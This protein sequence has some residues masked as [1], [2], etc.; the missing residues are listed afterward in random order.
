MIRPFTLRDLTLV[1]RLA[2]QGISLHAESAL[3]DSVN[4]L[5]GALLGIL[6][7]GN[8]PTFV[9][10]ST[11]SNE[12]GFL[13]LRLEEERHHAHI[14]CISPMLKQADA[15]ADTDADSIVPGI[16]SIVN[17]HIWLSLLDQAV[18]EAGRHG[19]HSLVAEVDETG[20]EL[21][22]L[23]RAG[24]AV[25][26][27]QDIWV[28]EDLPAAPASPVDLALTPRRVV[29][30]WDI[31]LL[32]A[33]TVPRL[34]QLAEPV[35]PLDGDE[36]W[37]LRD[38]DDLAAYVHIHL[39]SVATWLRFFI[40]PNAESDA[41]NIVAAALQVQSS[42]VNLPIFCCVRRYESWLP[43][44]LERNG[45]HIYSS[46]AVMVKHTVHHLKKPMSE[47]TAVLEKQGMT[48]STPI[49]QRYRPPSGAN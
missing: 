45:F 19:I 33:N 47:L 31:Q 2:E 24:F 11:E 26:T 13:Q 7:G 3:A 46:Q 36:A 37:V 9:W 30:D 43:S 23:R 10:K 15:D 32:Y 12:V 34:V 18:V 21:P 17:G 6:V 35:P 8:Q 29:D 42:K 40:H 44:A 25:Y 4:P 41:D 27:R 20:L 14:A 38:G 5:R 49:V 22:V 1:R 48:A 28:R 16:N 39:G